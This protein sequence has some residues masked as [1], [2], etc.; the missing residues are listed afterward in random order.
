MKGKKTVITDRF[1]RIIRR[2][3]KGLELAAVAENYAYWM[4]R[5]VTQDQVLYESFKGADVSGTP[6]LIFN[7]LLEQPDLKN[8]VHIWSISDKNMIEALKHQYASTANIRF[9]GRNDAS[10]FRALATSRYLIND[11]EFPQEFLKREEQLFLHT[12]DES[13]IGVN[14]LDSINNAIENR[15]IFRNLLS[16]DFLVSDSAHNTKN[17]LMDTFRLNNIFGGKIIEPELSSN[18]SDGKQTETA[19]S[20]VPQPSSSRSRHNDM[21]VQRIV[22][23]VFRN[24][25]HGHLPGCSR[26]TRKKVLLYPGG[27]VPNGITSSALNLLHNIDYEKFDVTV[28]CPFS[29]DQTKLRM[30][31]QLNPQARILFRDGRFAG[32][33]VANKLRAR[34]MLGDATSRKLLGKNNSCLWASEWLRCLGSSSFDHAVDF[35]GYSP[36]WGELYRHGKVMTRTIWL[37]ND[38]AA[39]SERVIHEHKP[40]HRNLQAVFKSYRHFDNLVSVSERLRDINRMKLGTWAQETKFSYA[41]NTLNLE[42]IR[43]LATRTINDA[44]FENP[45]TTTYSCQFIT[46]GRL[47]PEKNH[48]RLIEAFAQVHE[49]KPGSRLVI[50]GDG[51]LKSDLEKQAKNLGLATTITFTGHTD[52]PYAHMNDSDVFVLSSDYEGQPMVILEALVIGLPVIS[53]AFGSV[54]SAMPDGLGTIVE[55]DVDAL[56]TAMMQVADSRPQRV[57]FDAEAYNIEVLKEFEAL[58]V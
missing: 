41:R 43:S 39:D 34:A 55:C 58:F 10:Y 57:K 2:Y 56:A 18:E 14:G 17:L 11:Q 23:V 21:S 27:M 35:S 22:D 1:G 20:S 8:L 9:V 53:T 28:I 6:S 13:A 31:D 38:L 33:F 45:H 5:P 44:T 19:L 52:N 37:H 50:V 3:A 25:D 26:D 40:H 48:A 4:S 12:A 51:P 46:V 54:G 30:F 24:Q 29:N 42:R 36:F 49:R 32:G 16:A 47:S 15:N 7:H